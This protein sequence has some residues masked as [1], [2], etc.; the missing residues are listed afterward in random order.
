[1]NRQVGAERCVCDKQEARDER[2]LDVED[3]ARDYSAIRINVK[4]RREHRSQRSE[5]TRREPDEANGAVDT[6]RATSLDD[7]VKDARCRPG[8]AWRMWREKLTDDLEHVRR[9]SIRRLIQQVD[10]AGCQ[11]QEKWDRCEKD[12]E[13]DPACQ[14]KNVVFAAVV[15]DPLRVIAKQPAEP[16]REPALRH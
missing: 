13:R 1:R 8:V 14:K 9:R 12:V 15:P 4:N 5:Q 7:L 2:H 10:K 16:G 6:E 11:Q 3:L